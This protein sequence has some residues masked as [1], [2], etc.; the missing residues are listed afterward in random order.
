M[1]DFISILN[2]ITKSL[3][4]YIVLYFSMHGNKKYEKKRLIQG[5]IFFVVLLAFITPESILMNKVFIQGR[6]GVDV[7]F[8]NI[9]DYA[10]AYGLPI[11]LV[12]IIYKFKYNATV[13]FYFVLI[14]FSLRIG[15]EIVNFIYFLIEKPTDKIVIILSRLVFSGLWLYMLSLFRKKN[16]LN[17]KID[18]LAI[19]LASFLS[20]T[21]VITIVRY[22]ETILIKHDERVFASFTYVAELVI[23]ILCIVILTLHFSILKRQGE[24]RVLYSIVHQQK[25]AFDEFKKNVDFINIKVHDLKHEIEY[26][27][28]TTQGSDFSA[29]KEA[30]KKYDTQTLSDNEVLNLVF[31]NKQLA[32]EKEHISQI[33][34]ISAVDLDKVFSQE[35]IYSFFSNAIDNAIEYYAKSNIDINERYLEISIK[36]VHDNLVI[37]IANKYKEK[38]KVPSLITTK[39]NKAY[40]GFGTKSMKYFVN[41]HN[42]NI[43]FSIKN[44]TFSVDIML[45]IK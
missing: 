31:E 11:L 28:S 4:I 40:H 43:I 18:G 6:E 8:F 5:G 9:I 10:L 22:V 24:K 25:K 37:H 33:Y 16:L 27:E 44:E 30:L 39:K 1:T 34:N 45:P 7:I 21:I 32:L 2:D 3:F 14:F 19:I 35:E 20:T 38:D 23:T 26:L 17:E 29:T 12:A 13:F 15:S 36:T 41:R 42:G